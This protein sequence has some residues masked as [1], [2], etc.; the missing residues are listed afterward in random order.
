MGNV[1]NAGL[2]DNRNEIVTGEGIYEFKR[3]VI[4]FIL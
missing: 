4:I 3:S 2:E 1:C